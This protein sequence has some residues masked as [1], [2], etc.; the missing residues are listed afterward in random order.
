MHK[1]AELCVKR[2]V[3]ATM[4]IVALMVVGTFSFFTLGVDL[5]PKIDLPTVSVSVSNPGAS[6]EEVETDITK[7]IEDS[8][9]TISGIETITSS[10][11]SAG[12]RQGARGA[13]VRSGRHADHADRALFA[14]SAARGDRNRGQTDQAAA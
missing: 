12:H 11:R 8:V 6:A 13:E 3:F 1:L 10:Q 4:L 14:P 9:N 2:P 7:R 5:F